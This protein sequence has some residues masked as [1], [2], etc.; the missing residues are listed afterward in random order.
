MDPE[1][2]SH[3]SVSLSDLSDKSYSVLLLY[4]VP[5][6]LLKYLTPSYCCVGG[7]VVEGESTRFRKEHTTVES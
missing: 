6:C 1:L 4:G 7:C 5:L 3:R 2:V